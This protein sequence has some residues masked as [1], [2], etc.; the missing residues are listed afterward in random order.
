[1]YLG[2]DHSFEIKRN[3]IHNALVDCRRLLSWNKWIY[4]INGIRKE[5]RNVKGTFTP[6]QVLKLLVHVLVFI[7][8]VSSDLKYVQVMLLPN[9][10]K[11]WLDFTFPFAKGWANFF[12]CIDEV[13]QL[14][15]KLKYV[16]IHR[17]SSDETIGRIVKSFKKD[18]SR[19][20]IAAIRSVADICLYFT[21]ID[22]WKRTISS[23]QLLFCGLTSS[24]IGCYEAFNPHTHTSIE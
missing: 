9:L 17:Y 8:Q 19:H 14:L 1:M 12:S 6:R 23:R 11:T 21:W 3:N 10:L 18:I 24:V 16:S 15:L 2:S 4:Q 13:V 22:N 7:E 20:R 5:L